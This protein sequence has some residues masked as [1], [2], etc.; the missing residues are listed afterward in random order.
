LQQWSFN[1]SPGGFVSPEQ[2]EQQRLQQE[3]Q[4]KQMIDDK[5]CEVCQNTYLINDQITICS[6]SNE[7]VD[8]KDGQQCEN[9][10]ILETIKY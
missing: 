4:L 2:M 1:F 9:W 8:G 5:R 7:C 10:I 3:A 6:F